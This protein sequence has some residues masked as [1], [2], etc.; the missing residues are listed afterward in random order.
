MKQWTELCKLGI[1]PD[2]TEVL[3]DVQSYAGSIK[4]PVW[5]TTLSVYNQHVGTDSTVQL[6][7]LWAL[8]RQSVFERTVVC[9]N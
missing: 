5:P 3:V 2:K 1:S 4:C 7:P 9:M 8:H 6:P